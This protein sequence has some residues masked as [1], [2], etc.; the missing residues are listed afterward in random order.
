M[1][2]TANYR[3]PNYMSIVQG[4]AQAN[5]NNFSNTRKYSNYT[6]DSGAGGLGNINSLNNTLTYVV[7]NSSNVAGT[8][9]IFGAEQFQTIITP[10]G[11][12]S[13]GVTVQCLES[14]AQQVAMDSLGGFYVSG[15]KIETTDVT[16]FSTQQ[17][18]YNFR[19][20]AGST[21]GNVIQYSKFRNPINQDNKL[22]LA[23][24][25][26]FSFKVTGMHALTGGIVAG[27]EVATK[28]TF[29]FYIG[30]RLNASNV[31][32]NTP[33]VSVATNPYPS[34]IL[35]TALVSAG[36]ADTSIGG[37]IPVAQ[38]YMNGPSGPTANQ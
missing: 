37:G 27:G 32:D 11:G 28:L 38:R 30:A 31:F 12:C 5:P 15:G 23:D 21:T 29:T 3:N 8:W 20:S 22:L 34:A 17:M 16:Q 13:A 4:R 25:A 35:P 10:N 26:N 9:V 7:T 36:P 6:G 18:N 24:P 33:V 2:R 19:S 1:K 14:S